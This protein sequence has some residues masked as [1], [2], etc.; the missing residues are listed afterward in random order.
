M[1]FYL[2]RK[3]SIFGLYCPSFFIYRQTI[4]CIYTYQIL[5]ERVESENTRTKFCY[6]LSEQNNAVG[7]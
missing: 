4:M 5:T 1:S 3:Y 7:V 6:C 2:N